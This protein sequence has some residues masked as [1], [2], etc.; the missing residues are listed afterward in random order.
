[1]MDGGWPR[2]IAGDLRHHKVQ[3][4]VESLRG[5][6]ELAWARLVS[7]SGGCVAIAG[8]P[9][10]GRTWMAAAFGALLV[11]EEAIPTTTSSRLIRRCP[12]P[13]HAV[14]WCGGQPPT[15]TRVG[16]A[17]ANVEVPE[18]VRFELLKRA[19]YLV[20]E[21]VETAGRLGDWER[22][23]WEELKK[24]RAADGL[25]TVFVG[26]FSAANAE[27]AVPDIVTIDLNKVSA[28]GS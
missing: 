5:E 24:A 21:S 14:E 18:D 6:L 8:P 20:L 22:E 2:K 10:S 26:H 27:K 4:L 7:K 13:E 15:R 11:M 1:M 23:R 25:R 9:L 28:W 16:G 19:R 12:S 17:L 3:P